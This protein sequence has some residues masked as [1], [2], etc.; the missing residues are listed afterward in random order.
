MNPTELRNQLLRQIAILKQQK[1]VLRKML[2]ST[3]ELDK[4]FMYGGCENT[5]LTSAWETR[6]THIKR[7]LRTNKW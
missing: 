2:R 4:Y 1:R 5:I 7:I 6:K 3:L